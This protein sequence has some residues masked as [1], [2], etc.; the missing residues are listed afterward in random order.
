MRT[1]CEKKVPDFRAFALFFL[2]ALLG[3]C[4]REA[5]SECVYERASERASA[6]VEQARFFLPMITCHRLILKMKALPIFL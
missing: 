6:R 2:L 1:C 3:V 4:L 5:F